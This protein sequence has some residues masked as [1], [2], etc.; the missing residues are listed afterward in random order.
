MHSPTPAVPPSEQLIRAAQILA[1]A[2]DAQVANF[3]A[4]VQ[5]GDEMA[6]D[7]RDA[8]RRFLATAVAGVLIAAVTE[9][10]WPSS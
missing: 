8:C 5:V 2:A 6:L 1:A 10:V 9:L 4:F 3:P 7:F